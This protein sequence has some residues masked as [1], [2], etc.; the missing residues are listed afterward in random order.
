MKP[1]RWHKV[2][3]IFHAA[4]DRSPADRS[5]FVSDACH[6]DEELRK[7]VEALISSDG[8]S[9]T[10]LDSPAYEAA[11]EMIVDPKSEL[12]PGLTVGPYEIVS[13]ISRG[14]MGEVYLAVDRRLSRQVALKLLPAAFT[15]DDERLRRF[16]QEARAASALN[17]PNIITIFE[18]LKA[19]SSHLIA[20]EFVEGET[21]RQRLSHFALSVSE[22][23]NIA[24][25]VAD[26][27]S[28]AHKVGIVHRDIKPENIMLRPD[29]YVKVLDFGL[30]KLTEQPASVPAE[31]ALT[32]QV[33]TGS[34]VVI[35]TAG[36]MS[37]E[38]ARGK[39]VDARS[40]TFSL[41]AVLYEMVTGHKPFDGETPSDVLASI[42]RTDPPR[43]SQFL[44]EA[45]PELIR[46]IDKAL[47][48]NREERYQVVKDLLIDMKSLAQDLE[49]QARLEQSAA[50][51]AGA[52][53]IAA[54]VARPVM[55][56]NTVEPQ[57]AV[58]TISQALSVEL[59]RHPTRLIVSLAI[60]ALVLIA[61][62]VGLYTLLNRTPRRTHFQSSTIARITNSGKVIDARLSRDGTYLLYCLSDAGKQSL[63]L[64]QV[65]TANDKVIVPPASVGFFGFTFS[66]DDREIYYVI[67]ANY[68]AG[69]LY[70]IPVLGGTPTKILEKIDCPVT[71]SPNGKQM[72]FVRAN[73][74][75]EDQSALM[76][77]SIDGSSEQAFVTRRKPERFAP[78][79][80]TGPSWSPDGKLIAASVL[81]MGGL[82]RVV[83][84]PVN[85]TKEINLTPDPW[86]F[87]GQ[88]QWLPDMSGLLVVAG[89]NPST[90]AQL[91]FLSY[92]SGEKRQITNDLDQ[93]RTIGLTS[94]G[95]RFVNVVGS[96]VI[97]VFVAPDGDASRAIQLP[98]GNIGIGTGYGN[99]VGWTPDGRIVFSSAEG[100]E[101]NLWIMNADGT[102]RQQ[103]TSNLG[104]NIGPTISP[105]GRYVVFSSTRSGRQN[106]WRMNIDGASSKQLTQGVAESVPVVSPDGRWVVYTALGTTRPTIWKV[107][108]DGGEPTEITHKVSTTPTISPDGR[109]IAYLYTESPDPLVSPNKIAIIP[110]DGGEPVKTF[111]CQPPGTVQM[112][113]QWSA[114]AKSI[115]YNTN[116]NSVTNVWSQPLDG[117]APRQVTDFKDSFMTG[118]AYS[119]DGKQLACARGI[120]N[121][122]AVIISETN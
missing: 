27:L 31:E 50:S 11:A 7:E 86:P 94:D 46:I 95:S 6:G 37:P 108:I 9:G 10:F 72:A 2:K 67:K 115:L 33:R 102:N 82:S 104:R 109:F 81:T 89:T 58:T 88:V 107:S 36:Y 8:R 3:E 80:F 68:D 70:R 117:S 47:R 75:A 5:A 1:D 96:G 78:I 105:D 40:D 14:G 28:A 15:K 92:P 21:L 32:K 39:S 101:V 65:S 66:P 119:R 77:A 103:L 17:H 60:V 55:A 4:L 16:E 106:I 118:F 53:G 116:A 120:F 19:D 93:H 98:T 20:A 90:G 111:S 30:A 74:P 23:L 84:F 54:P 18:I 45:P 91:W 61:G 87:S 52:A 113:L 22:S 34:G 114:D 24:M 51:A 42:L 44:P 13:F 99:S 12:R 112:Y 100:N 35:G 41:G 71:F 26:A 122:D 64:R 59:K 73:F 121:R 79:F 97:S 85:G 56:Q 43:V 25:Q 110:L 83:A 49:F 29:G 63:W 38:Q 69:T 48:K 62:G 57:G 76:I